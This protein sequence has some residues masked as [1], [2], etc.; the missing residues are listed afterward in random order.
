VI[1]QIIRDPKEGFT[2]MTIIEKILNQY[3]FEHKDESLHT[4]KDIVAYIE[5]HLHNLQK[6]HIMLGAMSVAIL[7]APVGLYLH[8]FRLCWIASSSAFCLYLCPFHLC[9]FLFAIV[10]VPPS[11]SCS[12]LPR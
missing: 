7:E 9:V 1:H 5:D 3:D 2:L 4:F 8:T 10:P 11:I 6:S 12:Q